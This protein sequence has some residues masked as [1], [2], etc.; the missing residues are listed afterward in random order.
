L[1]KIL[2]IFTFILKNFTRKKYKDLSEIVLNS[3]DYAR[4][5]KRILKKEENLSS[6]D[7]SDILPNSTALIVKMT[8]NK[9]K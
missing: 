8:F 4:V 9:K 5:V 3:L 1:K 7:M 6:I 2:K